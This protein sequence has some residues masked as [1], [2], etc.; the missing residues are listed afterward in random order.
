MPTTLQPA[1]IVPRRV[2]AR[3]R[4]RV[5]ARRRRS[6]RSRCWCRSGFGIA[7]AVDRWMAGAARHQTD[8]PQPGA[9]AARDARHRR[10]PRG[11]A[12]R[13]QVLVDVEHDSPY[14][15]SMISGERTDAVRHGQRGRP[16]RLLR[17]SARSRSPCRD[18]RRIAT[19]ILPA[20]TLTS[21]TLDPTQTRIVGRERG[22][23]QRVDDAVS[24]NPTRRQRAVPAGR[25]EAR[26]RGGAERPH[27]RGPE[28]TPGR[29]SPGWRS[30]LGYESVTVN[31][32]SAGRPSTLIALVRPSE[33]ERKRR[34]QS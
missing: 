21:A 8:R 3:R 27:S 6:R 11:D 20:P 26:R 22:L 17:R 10:L 32:R 29:C 14:L 1:P 30:A 24:D 19:I 5:E 7:D 28:T 31:V 16:R 23:V 4:R 2:S 9:A 13:Y 33:T 34:W 25:G 15:P 18:D 12:A